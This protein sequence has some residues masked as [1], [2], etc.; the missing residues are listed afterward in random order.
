[1]QTEDLKPSIL[2]VDDEEDNLLVFKSS[3]RRNYKIYTAQS[4]AE[5]AGILNAHACDVIISDQRMPEVTGVQFLKTIPD[6]PDVFRMILTGFS[7][8]EAIIQAINSGKVHKYITKPWIKSELQQT[9]DE[10]VSY[11]TAKRKGLKQ[12]EISSMKEDTLQQQPDKEPA[13]QQMELE[14]LRLRNAESDQHVK[15]LSEIGQEIIANIN[16]DA[17]IESTYANVNALMDANSFGIAVFNDDESRL[18]FNC[19][20]EKGIKLPFASVSLSEENRPAVQCFRHQEEVIEN[21][22]K[23]EAITGEA[24]K[25]LIYLPL[26]I[27]DTPIGVITTQSF[28]KNAYSEYHVNILRNIAIYVATALENAKSYHLIEKQKTEIEQKNIE[29]ENKVAQRTLQLQQKNEEVEAQRDKLENTFQNIKLLSDIGQQITS[30]LSL[31]KIIET[32][33]KNINSLMDA[34]VFLIG[35]YDAGDERIN[36][37]GMEKGLNLPYFSLSIGEENW[38]AIWCFI[39]QREFIINDYQQEYNKYIKSIP[40]PKSG[41]Q[42]ESMIYLPLTI[43]EDKVGVISVQS[44]RKHVYSNYHIDILRSLGSYITIALQNAGSYH[45]MTH[46]FDELKQAQTKLVESEKMASLGVLTAG[47]AH[48]INNPVNFISAGIESLTENYEEFKELVHAFLEYNG[49]QPDPEKWKRIEQLKQ[50]LSPLDMMEEMDE[51]LASVKNGANRT[52]E[53]VKGLRNFTRLDEHDR[54]LF[55]VE[56]GLDSTLIILNNHLKN[57][58]DVIKNYGRVPELVG[59]PGQLNQVFMNLIYNAADAIPEK[60]KIEIKTWLE[61]ESIKISITDNG[62]GMSEEI[63]SRIFEPFYTTKDVGKGTGLGLSISFGIIEKHNGKI[64][65]DSKEGIGTTFTISLPLNS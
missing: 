21:D 26:L 10:G 54:K 34:T 36:I 3:F 20:I 30:T 23:M 27:K 44:F 15:L 56:E 8:M 37:Y 25:S 33:Y 18:E 22:F 19:W 57:R 28:S 1:M 58:V 4:A 7:D 42:P 17:I 38:P 39:N 60:G 11:V 63:R 50:K 6:E 31:E 40:K 47:V 43:L 49:Q 51:L 14:E 61:D 52:A 16:V 5:A 9:I 53:I 29:L 46:A 24:T 59:L 64:T 65:V 55:N 45:K 2:Y 12:G 48:E 13:S 35:I 62:K 32:V 41:E